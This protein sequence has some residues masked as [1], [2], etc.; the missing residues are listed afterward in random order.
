[1]EKAGKEELMFKLIQVRYRNNREGLVDDVTLN[2]LIRERKIKQF[3]HP[4]ESRWVDV[5]KDPVRVKTN[6]FMGPE[7]R[8]A[9]RP[10]KREKPPGLISKLLRRK[11][12]EKLTSAEEWFEKGFVLLHTTDQYQEALRAFA[13]AIALNPG[14]AR[15]YL[16]RGMAFER[17][18]NIE[19]AI[20]DYSCALEL[21][22]RDAKILY[23]L[24]ITFWRQNRT[25]EALKDI[26]AAA[27]LGYLSARNFLKAKKL[28][29]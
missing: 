14:D 7:R 15:A 19:Q 10:T 17:L 29:A 4:S 8:E 11:T 3:F 21:S 9:L 25:E 6:G 24:G 16:N 13:S 18:D 5:E 1:L 20:A 23:I 12:P 26:R 2:E 28:D 27:E 22:P